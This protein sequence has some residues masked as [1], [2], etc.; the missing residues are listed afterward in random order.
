[1]THTYDPAFYYF[2]CDC[3][4]GKIDRLARFHRAASKHEMI[5]QMQDRFCTEI[6]GVEEADFG[7]CWAKLTRAPTEGDF[8]LWSEEYGIPSDCFRVKP[9]GTH[10][11]GN[12]YWVDVTIPV[13]VPVFKTEGEE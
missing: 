12:F 3:Y 8:E 10:P 1:M 11:G 7:D 6:T 5:S 4:V 13:Y 9:P 2:A